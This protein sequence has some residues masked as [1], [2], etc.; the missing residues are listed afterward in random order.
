ML[1]HRLSPNAGV[2]PAGVQNR[3]RRGFDVGL[4][5][6]KTAHYPGDDSRTYLHDHDVRRSGFLC[7]H[8]C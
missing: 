1:Q 5:P 7:K 6:A 8:F 2:S 3:T 4:N